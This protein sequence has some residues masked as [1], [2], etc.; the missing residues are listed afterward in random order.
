MRTLEYSTMR[1]VACFPGGSCKQGVIDFISSTSLPQ[2]LEATT[3]QVKRTANPAP[4]PGP[5]LLIS[6]T[7]QRLRFSLIAH[8]DPVAGFFFSP[9]LL[10]CTIGTCW[11]PQMKA[12]S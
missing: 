8:V 5:L 2:G 10:F 11:T 9:T 1:S 7:K 4:P 3:L 6:L 12:Y